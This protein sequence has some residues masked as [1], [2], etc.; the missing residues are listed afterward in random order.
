MPAVDLPR[1]PE[2]ATPAPAQAA[3]VDAGRDLLERHPLFRHLDPAAR[4]RIVSFAR[5]RRVA[6][7]ETI[8]LKGSAGTSM[9]AVLAGQVRISALSPQG[10]EIVLNVINPGEVFGEIALLDG[11]ERTADAVAV[12]DAELLVLERR[13]V[14]GFLEA[15]PKACITLL[16][17]LCQRVRQTTEQVEDMVFLPLPGRIAKVL[18]RLT[19]R[20][21]DRVRMSQRELGVAVG[22]TRES[23]NKYLGDLR[24]RRIIALN[25]GHIR[26]CDRAALEV[27]L[28]EI[29]ERD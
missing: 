28:E 19:K 17:T 22:G 2:P 7:G 26:V 29:L 13:D 16:E 21:G 5:A 20:D 23:M 1:R 12:S 6:A 3:R 11:K 27:A 14:V 4:R 10:K 8:F 24:R 25:D 9:M 18:L 15:H